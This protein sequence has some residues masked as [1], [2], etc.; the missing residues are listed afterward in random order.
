MSMIGI[1]GFGHV[2]K[3]MRT[4][5]PDAVIYDPAY[6]ASARQEDIN[7]CQIV[8]V[9]VPTPM[10]GSGSADVSIVEEVVDWID[11]GAVIVIKSTVTPGTTDALKRRTG[12]RIVFSP[13]YVGESP[14]YLPEGFRPDS[15]PFVIVGGDN[16]DTKPVMNL[17]IEKLG[18]TKTYRQTTALQAEICKY[19]ENTWLA[20]QVIFANQF[21]DIAESAGADY[22]ELRELW[23]LDP[24]VSK[25]HTAV[26]ASRRGYSGKCLPKDVAAIHAYARSLGVPTALL[27]GIERANDTY[28]AVKD[29]A[30]FTLT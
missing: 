29:D 8:F 6:A 14:Y 26:F 12:K 20:M 19:M 2:G 17:H 21:F 25:W 4:L 23:A 22:A 18:P 24:R 13:E 7:A 3:S 11:P 16:A 15:W 10:T 5:F 28:T 9:C 1:V 27:D 30:F